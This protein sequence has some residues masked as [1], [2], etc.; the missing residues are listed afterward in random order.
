MININISKEP[1][2]NKGLGICILLESTLDISIVD[3]LGFPQAREMVWLLHNW[4]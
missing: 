1:S 2:C 4:N 3:V